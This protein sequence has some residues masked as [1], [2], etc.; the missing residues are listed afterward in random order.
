M[1]RSWQNPLGRHAHNLSYHRPAVRCFD[2]SFTH[3]DF[4]RNTVLERS[5]DF[6]SNQSY[7]DLRRHIVTQERESDVLVRTEYARCVKK[8]GEDL[9]YMGTSTVVRD[10]DFITKALEGKDAL[11]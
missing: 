7:D 9:K 2:D 3:A 4:K 5:Y 10:M 6:A 8:L 1:F 11:M